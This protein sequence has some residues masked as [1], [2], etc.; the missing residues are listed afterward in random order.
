VSSTAVYLN[1][2]TPGG[3]VAP[4]ASD[5]A[6]NREYRAAK[7]ACEMAV[8]DALGDR[9]AIAR[10]GLIGGPGD[11]T[12]RSGYWPARFELAGNGPVLV[13]GIPDQ[14]IGFTDAR[15]LAR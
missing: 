7:V 8:L 10:V 12:D 6:A 2:A 1:A 4:L 15:D 3:T 14:P 5:T 11:R 13:P 9:A